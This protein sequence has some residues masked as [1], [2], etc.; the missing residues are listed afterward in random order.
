M[1]IANLRAQV[2]ST[3]IHIH[4]DDDKCKKRRSR[5]LPVQKHSPRS[6]ISEESMLEQLRFADAYGHDL[7]ERASSLLSPKSPLV[8]LKLYNCRADADCG[9]STVS[10]INEEDLDC[11]SDASTEVPTRMNSH[12]PKCGQSSHLDITSRY[13]YLHTPCRQMPAD[14]VAGSPNR[15]A[16]QHDSATRK[17]QRD[18]TVLSTTVDWPGRLQSSCLPRVRETKDGTT[19]MLRNIA[20]RY[21]EADVKEILDN[22]GFGGTYDAVYVPMRPRPPNHPKPSNNGYAFVDFMDA[23][24]ASVCWRQINGT[25]FGWGNTGKKCEVTLASMQGYVNRPRNASA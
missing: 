10:T 14:R 2:K 9:W 4:D 13:P 8:G 5:S 19:L 16:C 25:T 18:A 12:S 3:F 6:G 22:L 1:A 21:S 20:C 23:G 24:S 17:A 11:Q 15:K 7:M